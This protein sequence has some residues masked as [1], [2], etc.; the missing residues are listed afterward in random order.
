MSVGFE[1]HKEGEINY[2]KPLARAL[3]RDR[4]LS[5]G[6]RGLFAFLWDLPVGWRTNSQH[7]STMS[8]MGRDAIRTVLKEL[9]RV[10]AMRSESI[11]GEGGKMAGKRWILV[12]PDRWANESSLSS[13]DF[14]PAPNGGSTERRVFRR[15]EKPTVGESNTKVLPLE[16]SPNK[17]TTNNQVEEEIDD[18]VEAALWAARNGGGK[19]NKEAGFRYRVRTRIRSSGPSPEDMLSLQAWRAWRDAHKPVDQ[20]AN[21]KPLDINIDLDACAKGAELLPVSLRARA[22]MS[23]VC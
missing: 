17:S 21:R 10:G 1:I 9:E 16:G 20:Q 3:V 14:P 22:I 12:S 4:R 7:L 2:T 15:S 23:P 6:A 8:P 19:V 18:L 5:F 13:K 11:R